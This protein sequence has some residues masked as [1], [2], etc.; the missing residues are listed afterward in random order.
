MK[1]LNII[2]FL[3]LF[4]F[5]VT[6]DEDKIRSS[7]KNILPEGSKI[8]S[9]KKSNIPGLY[10]V[11]YGDLEP[12]YVSEDG[13]FFIY[14]DIY[15]I[16]SNSITNITDLD[17]NKRRSEILMDL[18]SHKLLSFKA[19]KEQYSVVVFTD[20]DCGYCRKLHKEI[21]DYNDIGITINYAAFPRSG[22]GSEAFSKM[23]GAWCSNNKKLSLTKLK[24]DE[25]IAISFCDDQPVSKHFVIGKK[26]GVT[27][28]PAIF[29][30]DGRLF[31]GYL[32]AEELLIKLKS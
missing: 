12:I 9:I 10:T 6:A 22:I 24:N 25:D 26:L 28:T 29:S 17:I 13:S 23:V 5:S 2:L 30:L 4:S 15:K 31:P 16:N 32:S 18:Q 1:L 19:E 7:L 27:G 11:Y 14:G 3:I 20:V 21:E 8:E